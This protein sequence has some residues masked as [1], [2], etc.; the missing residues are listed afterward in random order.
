MRVRLLKRAFIENRRCLPGEVV[1]VSQAVARRWI[2]K[3]MAEQYGLVS[4]IKVII[5]RALVAMRLGGEK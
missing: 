5:K 2:G 4:K 1:N 3:G